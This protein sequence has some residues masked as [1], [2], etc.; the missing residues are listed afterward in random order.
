M[1][2]LA[3]HISMRIPSVKIVCECFLPWQESQPYEDKTIANMVLHT[4]DCSLMA[5]AT[6]LSL[7]W[8]KAR[9]G[10]FLNDWFSICFL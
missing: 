10:E 5:E 1:Q 7:S 2:V 8:K 6:S 4:G 3:A 9:Y